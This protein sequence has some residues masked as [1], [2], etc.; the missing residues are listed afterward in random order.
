MLVSNLERG[1]VSDL[2][3]CYADSQSK[4]TIINIASAEETRT[5][6]DWFAED[7]A[8]EKRYG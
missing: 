2:T 7:D 5:S 3:F 6:I 1:S 8:E 4:S